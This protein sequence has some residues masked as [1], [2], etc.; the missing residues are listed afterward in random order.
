LTRIAADLEHS[1]RVTGP[2]L[3]VEEPCPHGDVTLAPAAATGRSEQETALALSAWR[4]T[5]PARHMTSA[6][7]RRSGQPAPGPL[8][9]R[10]AA[11][12]SL[13]RRRAGARP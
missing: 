12:G 10:L 6:P 11:L 4:P 3:R 1:M 9:V 8:S 13:M 5:P 7:W 2:M